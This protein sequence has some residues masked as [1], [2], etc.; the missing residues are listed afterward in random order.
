M[1]RR[2]RQDAA[3]AQRQINDVAL[4]LH[5]VHRREGAVETD[6]NPLVSALVHDDVG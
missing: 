4:P 5:A 6:G 1:D 3:A 2:L